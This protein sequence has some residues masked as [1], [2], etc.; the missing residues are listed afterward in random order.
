MKASYQQITVLVDD[1]L[2]LRRLETDFETRRDMVHIPDVLKYTLDTFESQAHDKGIRLTSALG[3]GI[4][5][6]RANSIRIR[7]LLDNLVGNAIKYTPG[8]GEV[9]VS[10][11]ARDNQV[12]LEVKDTGLGIP[13]NEQNR[14]FEK[15]YRASNAPGAVQ[16]TG[17]GLSIVKSIVESYHG[18]IWVESTPG[19]GSSFFVVLPAHDQVL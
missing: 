17:L 4:P 16:G 1:L 19:Q 15:F 2:H 13:Q 12:I 7:Q 18:R 3:D 5:A 14:I 8:S 9:H 6:V 10:I 11:L